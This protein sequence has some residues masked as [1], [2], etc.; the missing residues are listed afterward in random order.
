MLI[1][2]MSSAVAMKSRT[3]SGLSCSADGQECR[4]W[5]GAQPGREPNLASGNIPCHGHHAQFMNR[6]WAGSRDPLFWELKLFCEFSHFGG[7]SAKS[8][9]SMF[10]SHCL[11]TGYTICY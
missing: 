10:R 7:S 11:G 6:G 8:V 9:S 5:E 1:T 4:S 3:F 2:L